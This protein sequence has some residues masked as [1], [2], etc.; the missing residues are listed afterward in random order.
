MMRMRMTI[1]W[2]VLLLGTSVAG[3]RELIVGV[4]DD[5]GFT[6][7]DPLENVYGRALRR[8]G[9]TPV[10]VACALDSV[11][12]HRLLKEVDVV[13]LT[14]GEDVNPVRYGETPSPELG[15]VNERR[16]TFEYRVLAEAVR[17]K[18]PIFGTC[19]GEQMINVF[20]G[21]TLYQDIPS[22]IPS[23]GKHRGVT[24]RVALNR[25]SR[26]YKVLGTDSI[27]TNSYH[28]QAV[29]DL[30]PGFYVTARSEDGVVE[31]IESKKY[32]V[33][34]VQFHPELLWKEDERFVAIYKQLHRLCRK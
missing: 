23:A 5:C 12:L 24:H 6:G 17:L 15:I 22:E 20:F 14:G 33:A 32:P 3:A 8:G 16:D 2:L 18:K 26:L 27:D 29:K 19:R 30:A 9:H 13:F 31:A 28:H 21:G 1:V 7:D 11:A 4:V 34:A 10:F 25:K